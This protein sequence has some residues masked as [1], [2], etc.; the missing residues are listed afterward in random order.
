MLIIK[1]YPSYIF[2]REG[3]LL[4]Q[5]GNEIDEK[6]NSTVYSNYYI[7]L[8]EK[9]KGVVGISPTY[10]ALLITYN[11]M[12]IGYKQLLGL[13]KQKIKKQSIFHTSFKRIINIP[14]CYDDIFALD[15]NNV[16]QHTGLSK[17]EII[18]LHSEQEYKVYM[19]GFLPGF[20]YLGGMN[21]R[22]NT[23]RLTNPRVKIEAG[24]IGIGG[25]QTGIYPLASPGGWQI[26]GKTPSKLYDKNREPISLINPGDWV[27]FIPITLQ[28]YK[29]ME[30][31]ENGTC[32]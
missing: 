31:G 27:K 20:P 10:T 29:E 23:P 9:I 7:L 22:L 14:V 19:I 25:E 6:I 17:E 21:K 13:V 16:K 15:I 32:Q 18:T 5:F 2:L 30:K 11:P 28:E 26:I 24:S 4:V 8:K 1:D 12:I 3:A